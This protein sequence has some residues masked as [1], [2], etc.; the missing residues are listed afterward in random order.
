[1]KRS[2]DKNSRTIWLAAL[3]TIFIIVAITWY[4]FV[5]NC[6]RYNCGSISWRRQVLVRLARMAAVLL[7]HSLI[8]GT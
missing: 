6:V 1:M 4:K 7:F 3:A 5:S 8:Q 2:M